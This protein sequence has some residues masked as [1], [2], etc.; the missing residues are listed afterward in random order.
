MNN[1]F[2]I[3]FVTK[4]YAKFAYISLPKIL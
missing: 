3:K 2:K 4:E 1:D